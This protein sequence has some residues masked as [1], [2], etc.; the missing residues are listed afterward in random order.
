MTVDDEVAGTG[1]L[2]VGAAGA[3]RRVG[4]DHRENR[5]LAASTHRPRAAITS[6]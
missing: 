5:R 3:A 2:V 1:V 4:L 6:R